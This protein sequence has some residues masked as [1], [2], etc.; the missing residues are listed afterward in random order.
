M[1]RHTL[2][3]VAD[4]VADPGL[5]PTATYAVDPALVR[6]LTA[7]VV[8][9]ARPELATTH[10]PMTGAPLASLPMS[11][12]ADVTV[13]YAGARAA[14]R[15]WAR[16]PVARRA[17]IVLRFHDLVL[18]RRDALLDLIQL[19]SG[20]ARAHAFEEIGD[21][22]QVARH[23]ARRAVGYLRPRRRFAALPMLTAAA[24]VRRP[25]GV[26]G[27]VSPWNYPLTLSVTEAIPALLAGN[28]VVLH[29][30]T[31][32][33]L[34]AL[35]AAALLEE[36]GLPE[37]V[38]QIVLGQGAPV[39]REVLAQADYV[40]FTG[41]TSVGRH[42]AASAGR[43]LVGASLELGGKNSLYVAADADLARAAAGAVRAASPPPGR[44]ASRPSG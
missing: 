32:A 7:R 2:L 3:S 24:E 36:A 42:V 29:P 26:V 16:T 35:Q 8:C 17:R 4:T 21:T 40:S 22:A 41:S 18:D 14:Q 10:T 30:D 5:D 9:A 15:A 11:T 6:G 34:T 44:C 37:R 12:T 23:Y 31:Q 38:L 19:E 20:K 28:A 27:L 43:H 39:P 25:R 33:A 13:A 1:A